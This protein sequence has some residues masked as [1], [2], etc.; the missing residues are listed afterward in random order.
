[1]WHHVAHSRFAER[2]IKRSAEYPM[3]FKTVHPHNTVEQQHER[4]DEL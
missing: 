1:M 3:H 2:T 4:D